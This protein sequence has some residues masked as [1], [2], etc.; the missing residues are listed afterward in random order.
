MKKKNFIE[1]SFK[2][3]VID[4]TKNQ[5][6]KIIK[7]GLILK[8]SCDPEFDL[9]CPSQ[10]VDKNGNII[11]NECSVL[12]K[13]RGNVIVNHS[14]EEMKNIIWG[15]DDEEKNTIGFKFKNKKKK[16]GK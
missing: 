15:N 7:K 11:K 1:L 3:D 16:N 6:N 8:M 5:K 9:S 10:I 13:D 14:Y 2:I 12:I 4:E